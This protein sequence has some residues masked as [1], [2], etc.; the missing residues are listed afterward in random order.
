MKNRF[1][2]VYFSVSLNYYRVIFGNA[3][4]FTKISTVSRNDNIV[5]GKFYSEAS[6]GFT[7]PRFAPRLDAK[8]MHSA[9][10]KG[11]VTNV[12]N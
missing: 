9:A 11:F 2:L 6:S 4:V 10:C 5:V 8:Y 12:M 7:I 3:Y 1:V